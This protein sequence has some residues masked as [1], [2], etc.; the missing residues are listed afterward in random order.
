MSLPRRF[1]WFYVIYLAG[2]LTIIL[3]MS[4]AKKWGV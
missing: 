2:T 1:N 4:A 3:V